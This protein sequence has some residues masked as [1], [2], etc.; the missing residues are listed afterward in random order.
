M[1]SAGALESYLEAACRESEHVQWL[2]G[3]SFMRA[4]DGNIAVL[5]KSDG[6]DDHQPVDLIIGA[7]GPES[8]VRSYMERKCSEFSVLRQ[9]V[10]EATGVK[11]VT[12]E[13]REVH[14][15]VAAAV[16]EGTWLEMHG[17]GGLRATW[18][19]ADTKCGAVCAALA[20]P[21][22][23]WNGMVNSWDGTSAAGLKAAFGHVF[24]DSTFLELWAKKLQGC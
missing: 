14:E 15:M 21:G 13:A 7:D 6:P 20:A 22:E 19:P 8:R 4:V 10:P 1:T 23:F 18:G 17:A 24:E 16:E 5:R 9:E 2:C 12:F 11:A 3:T